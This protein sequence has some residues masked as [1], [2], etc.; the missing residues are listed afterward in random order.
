M[1][2]NLNSLPPE[3]CIQ[4]IPNLGIDARA[5]CAYS[6][7][8]KFALAIIYNIAGY[9]IELS[10]KHYEHICDENPPLKVCIFE[11]LKF[12]IEKRYPQY[13]HVLVRNVLRFNSPQV[14]IP[15]LDPIGRTLA[16]VIY[17]YKDP[18]LAEL[19]LVQRESNNIPGVKRNTD[20]LGVVLR[21]AIVIFNSPKIVRM[22]LSLPNAKNI[23][24]LG[25]D[26]LGEAL[27]DAAKQNSLEL[28]KLILDHNNAKDIQDGSLW[29]AILYAIKVK[30]HKIIYKIARHPNAKDICLSRKPPYGSEIIP[31]LKPLY[32]SAIESQ[33]PLLIAAVLHLPKAIDLPVENLI[34]AG[35]A[36][37]SQEDRATL[38][39]LHQ[40]LEHKKLFKLQKF[41]ETFITLTVCAQYLFYLLLCKTHGRLNQTIAKDG[42]VHLIKK[43]MSLL[44]ITDQILN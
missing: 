28:T 37:L 23:V 29:F 24:G 3:L 11:I 12:Q 5:L 39:Q 16:G 18:D 15:P 9:P 43:P 1:S 36:M 26:S 31:G 33:D 21:C 34:I 19:V 42:M 10:E 2:V 7:T 6:R 25:R 40:M 27:I 44:P 32:E 35:K 30:N 41:G 22:I 4:I 38:L 20:D 8:S 14:I 13:H 17:H